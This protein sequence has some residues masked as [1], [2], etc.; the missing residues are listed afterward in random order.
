M[1][2]GTGTA[3]FRATQAP[4]RLPPEAEAFFSHQ[5]LADPPFSCLNGAAGFND[6]DGNGSNLS[7]TRLAGQ[8]G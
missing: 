4:R 2:G 7:L 1:T 5:P 6:S 3:E 8:C